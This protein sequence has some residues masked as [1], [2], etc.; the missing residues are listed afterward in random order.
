MFRAGLVQMRSGPDFARNLVNATALIE[1]AVASGAKYIQ[2]PEVTN[3]F[4]PDKQR[5]KAVVQAEADDV[6]VR[7]FS[8]LAAKHQIYLH[9]GSCA[10]KA[11]DGR[12]ANRSLL[13]APDGSVMARYDKVHLFDIELPTGE[14]H[15][16]SATFRAGEE[17]VVVDTPLCILG[18]AICYDVRF[19]HL[20][21]ALSEA[22]ANVITVPAAF[23]VPTGEAHWHVLLRARAIET[24]AYVLAAAQGGV[25]EGGRATYG[26]SL[27]ISPWGEILAE[28]GT[29][30]TFLVQDIDPRQSALA[31]QR[32]PVNAH[33][34]PFALKRFSADPMWS[35]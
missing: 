35:P 22:G 25:H 3:I 9:A 29:E 33:A 16:E 5:L 23:T 4:E 12:L 30:P 26:H 6:C 14:S 24:G 18:L 20:F 7:G 32:I 2:T 11:D 13:F 10:V 8:E 15:K 21:R 1:A 28:A 17:A 34:R 31:Q 19:S 27:M